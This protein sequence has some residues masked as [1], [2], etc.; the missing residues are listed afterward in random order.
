M[1]MM[2]DGP[3]NSPVV[4]NL[5][6]TSLFD[7]V[8]DYCMQRIFYSAKELID[9]FGKLTSKEDYFLRF[10]IKLAEKILYCP[11]SL[12]IN[13]PNQI[14]MR[15]QTIA[16]EMKQLLTTDKS[17]F[18]LFSTWEEILYQVTPL[19][20][21]LLSIIC[22]NMVEAVIGYIF[23]FNLCVSE[24]NHSRKRNKR[25]LDDVEEEED[26]FYIAS[27]FSKKSKYHD[28]YIMSRK[29]HNILQGENGPVYR[30]QVP[31]PSF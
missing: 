17:L 26:D 8:R 19:P 4:S 12:L 24:E 16:H 18:S 14:I 5:T 31:L 7:F 21:H 3:E 27:H 11:E 10:L 23:Q 9:W 22:D 20:G 15:G 25:G 2:I 29:T 13:N 28:D 6:S 1:S 30:I